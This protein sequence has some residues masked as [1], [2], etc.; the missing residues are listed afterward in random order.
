MI[1]LGITPDATAVVEYIRTHGIP[2]IVD[3]GIRDVTHIVEILVLGVSAISLDPCF[4]DGMDD[5]EILRKSFATLIAD[6]QKEC[7]NNGCRALSDL[8]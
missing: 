3:G 7:L 4:I 5:S 8:Q 6:V 1:I 2:I